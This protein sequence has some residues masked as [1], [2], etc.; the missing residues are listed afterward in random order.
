MIQG[1]FKYGIKGPIYFYQI[2]TKEEKKIRAYQLNIENAEEQLNIQLAYIATKA[3][4]INPNTRR[5]CGGKAAS[6]NN[7]I[8]KKLKTRGDRL[9]SRVNQLIHR[10]GGL[11]KLVEQIQELCIKHPNR[12]QIIYEDRARAYQS[13]YCQAVFNANYIERLMDLLA[14]SLELNSIEH[15]QAQIRK[16]ITCKEDRYRSISVNQ[17]EAC[18]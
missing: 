7:F 8:K 14:R 9:N 1:V 3:L 10:D 17:Q 11:A 6:I 13:P 16:D 2:E 12:E 15:A 18:N 5:R 4:K